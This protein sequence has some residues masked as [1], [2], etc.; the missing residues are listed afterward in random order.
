[1]SSVKVNAM[2]FQDLDMLPCPHITTKQDFVHELLPDPV[3]L[4]SFG[5]MRMLCATIP[6]TVSI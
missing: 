4:V 3:D 1:M 2:S 6:L 5:R